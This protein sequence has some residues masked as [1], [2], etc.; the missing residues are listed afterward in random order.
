MLKAQT[1]TIVNFPKLDT[2]PLDVVYFPV[3]TSKA[4]VPVAPIIRVLYSRPQK[5]GREIFG[6]LE[7][8]GKVWRLGANEN[9]EIQFF[10]SVKINGKKIKAGRYS[11]FAIPDKDKW[12]VIINHQKDKWGAFSYDE[13]KDVVRIDVPIE[14]LEKVI[15][16]FSIAFKETTEGAD[17][18]MAWDTT[19]TSLPITFKK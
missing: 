9:T 2:S 10:K 7:Q 5:K 17:L 8:F 18:V 11:L 14:R 15:D 16:V 19:Q 6:V 3:N 4:K 13:Q 12:T 1:N